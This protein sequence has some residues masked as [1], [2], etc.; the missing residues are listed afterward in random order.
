MLKQL[1]LFSL[2][3][4]SPSFA[5]AA[6]VVGKP[7]P[8]FELKDTH[9]KTV[10]LAEL[11]KENTV[12][13]EWLNYDCPFVRKHYDSKNMQ[14]LQERYTGKGVKWFSI[15]S[16]AAGKQG[17]YSPEE[18][19]DLNDK[20]GGH[21]TAILLDNTG[22]VGKAYGAKTTPHMFVI[23]KGGLLAYAGAIDDKPSTDAEDVI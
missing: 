21:P 16:S 20:K 8:A 15:I 4:A 7:A 6:A 11:A 2:L 17:A 5:L 18:L 3:L 23:R 13:L 22:S 14:G 9:G 12:V 1:A 19:N 10:N